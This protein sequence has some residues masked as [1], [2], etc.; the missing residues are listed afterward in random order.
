MCVAFFSFF[1]DPNIVVLF[2]QLPPYVLLC[3]CSCLCLCSYLWLWLCLRGVCLCACAVL[4]CVYVF[5]VCL[6]AFLC[7]KVIV[8]TYL[9]FAEFSFF[10][11]FKYLPSSLKER[12]SASLLEGTSFSLPHTDPMQ[13]FGRLQL[14]L[15]VNSTK[16]CMF[17]R[18]D[19]RAC[20]C[21]RT[22]ANV[23]IDTAKW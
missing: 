16:V 15:L 5:C 4:E 2:L 6:W 12:I 10:L 18:K 8:Y 7:E 14:L 13:V 21:M 1:T 11:L 23:S 20:A 17:A 9:F 19:T 22:R 3:L